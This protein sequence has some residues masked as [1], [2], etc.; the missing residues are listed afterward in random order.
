[1]GQFVRLLA[2]FAMM[3]VTVLSVTA[4]DLRAHRERY[5]RFQERYESEITKLIAW[6]QENNLTTE[7]EKTRT[8]NSTPTAEDRAYIGILPQ[9]VQMKNADTRVSRKTKEKTKETPQEEWERR[10]SRLRQQASNQLFKLSQSAMDDGYATYAFELLM[11]TL[12]ENPDHTVARKI[13]GYEQV[14]GLWLSPF[15]KQQIRKN[16]YHPKFGWLPSK[17]VER[18]ENGERFFRGKWISQKQ[19]AAVHFDIENGWTVET[20]HFT[21]VTNHSLP[22]AVHIG[23]E[24]EVLYRVWKQFFLRFFATDAQLK[25]LF[26]GKM[27]SATSGI[28]PG[29]GTNGKHRIFFFRNQE[30]YVKY[31][32]ERYPQV[33]QSCGIYIMEDRTSYFFAGENFDRATMLHEVTHQLFNE[34]RPISRNARAFDLTKSPN[35]WMIEGISTYMESLHDEGNYHVIGGFD[36]PR[37][38]AA[39]IR[40]TKGNFYIPL[41]ELS[42]MN[43]ADFQSHPQMVRLYSQSSGLMQFLLHADDGQYRDGV[44]DILRDIYTGKSMKNTIPRHLGRSFEELDAEYG[45]YISRNQEE[46]KQWEME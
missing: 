29:M 3:F 25:A 20:P 4:E 1:M 39:R 44:S 5:A 9:E 15:E 26:D 35:F 36:T 40:Y 24:V 46:L 38:L 33:A 11:R 23:E 45:K 8:L 34:L 37:L 10:F 6:C 18:Y 7:A 17:H 19:D 42:A 41:E 2:M 43:T 22:V 28:E 16:V 12:E 27:A 21:V 32:S 14:D 13:L 31:L 30:N